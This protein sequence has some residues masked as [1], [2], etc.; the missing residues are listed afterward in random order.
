MPS[1]VRPGRKKKKSKKLRK[2]IKI[3]KVGKFK[4]FFKKKLIKN[5]EKKQNIRIFFFESKKLGY[6]VEMASKASRKNY[7]AGRGPVCTLV[8][9]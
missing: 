3:I 6:F 5:Y 9:T 7:V 2:F 8:M 4:K 1:W